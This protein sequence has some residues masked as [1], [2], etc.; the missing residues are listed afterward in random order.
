[1]TGARITGIG[2]SLPDKVVTN[3]DLAATLDTSDEWIRE[4]SG[5]AERRVGTSTTQLGLEAAQK[6]LAMAGVD[7]A[8]LD[9]IMFATTTPDNLFP[10][11]GC[12]VQHALG[13]HKAGALDLN[14]A[15]SGFVY[16]LIGA[17]GYVGRGVERVLVIG[18][19]TISRILD[20]DDRSTAVLFGDGAGAVVIEATDD[21]NDSLLGWHMGSKG[22]LGH[23]LQCDDIR[24]TIRMD[25]KEVFRQAILA[26]E[27]TVTA[28]LGRASMTI[29]DIDTIVMHQAN[30][31]I[32]EAACKRLGADFDKVVH[33]I[34]HT[35]NTS[36]ASIPLALDAGV[37][38]GRITAG[39]KLLLAG[40]GA[41]MTYASAVVE[42]GA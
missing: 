8:D 26:V 23:I 31:R 42:W 15:C 30:I 10:I 3:H 11:G 21:A 29:D 6:A 28:T 36:S 16:S 38:T 12:Q 1:M 7:P 4:R 17:Y 24:D 13:A 34:E 40:F 2:T 25:G 35:A 5:I 19:E 33:V 32:M 9:L 20:W 37:Q 41:G 18:A 22:S 14:A 39:D 27:E